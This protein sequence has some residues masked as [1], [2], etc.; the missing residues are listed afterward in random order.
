MTPTSEPSVTPKAEPTAT[1]DPLEGTVKEIVR[2]LNRHEQ[3]GYPL[4]DPFYVGIYGQSRYEFSPEAA[5][6]EM[7]TRYAG[8][9]YGVRSLSIEADLSRELPE[10]VT[11]E[12]AKARF[13]IDHDVTEIVYSSGWGVDQPAEALFYFGKENG[14]TL[15]LGT[16]YSFNGFQETDPYPAISPP[17]SVTALLTA[18]ETR[19]AFISAL[20]VSLEVEPYQ[21]AVDRE[22]NA[23][24]ETAI[25]L[26]QIG[27]DDPLR[28][29]MVDIDTQEERLLFAEDMLR[30]T[31]R[32]LFPRSV[33]WLNGSTALIGYSNRFEEDGPNWGRL[34]RIDVDSGVIEPIDLNSVIS[35]APTKVNG[36]M[37][38]FA[39][40]DGIY[41]YDD[42][43]REVTSLPFVSDPTHKLF[44]SAP[45]LSP[46]GRSLI[47][48]AFD[49]IDT[50]SRTPGRYLLI[51]LENGET[52]AVA[53]FDFPPIGG[54][55][56]PALWGPNGRYALIEP[57]GIFAEQDGITLV[58]AHEPERSLF[59]GIGSSNGRWVPG[60]DFFIFDAMVQGER[61]LHLFDTRSWRRFQSSALQPDGVLVEI[62]S[63]PPLPVDDPF[64]AVNL[65]LEPA[66]EDELWST[67]TYASPD[68]QWIA[69]ARYYQPVELETAEGEN[70][71]RQRNLLHVAA[72][73]G[74]QNWRVLD[75]LE[76]S[77]LGGGPYRVLDWGGDSL[78]FTYGAL[79]GGCGLGT[80]DIGIWS[81]DLVSGE[82]M[83]HLHIDR[84]WIADIHVASGQ[85]AYI[86]SNQ[87][88]DSYR[89]G[90]LDLADGEE[91]IYQLPLDHFDFGDLAWSPQGD[92]LLFIRQQGNCGDQGADIY[93][94]HLATLEVE[95]I[96]S[97][98][99]GP[100]F[101]IQ[102]ISDYLVELNVGFDGERHSLDLLTG[103][104][105]KIE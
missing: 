91:Q 30:M 19:Q 60:T 76:P 71:Y 94:A 7:R 73:D 74:R 32:D 63:E 49:P 56:P 16:L 24:P 41:R 8:D 44:L 102:W 64:Q 3:D 79:P 57:L 15:W 47:R 5:L 27:I 36:D 34:A 96:F 23:S 103:D 54:G 39:T 83:Q 12:M 70:K 80:G 82:V 20:M 89:I 38:V 97:G 25:V 53:N 101:E 51:D 46:N 31:G 18:E 22:I 93:V 92:R 13:P 28:L 48:A 77:E 52:A 86:L 17:D 69:T 40:E 72:V 75:E 84:G 58:D 55:P 4:A 104:L 68:G 11:F 88:R 43:L 98:S 50:N 90:I 29:I 9:V 95:T 100:I 2:K 42:Q 81:L 33:M 6:Y 59:L 105:T 78:Y 21:L 14:Q 67:R 85:A 45:A 62:E 26:P 1:L 66:V 35:L 10:G 37:A 87:V 99:L 65:P 61:Q